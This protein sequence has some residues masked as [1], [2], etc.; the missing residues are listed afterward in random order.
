MGPGQAPGDESA[1]MTASLVELSVALRIVGHGDLA[2]H[3][4]L[5][6][7][8]REGRR[9]Y[10]DAEAFGHVALSAALSG[11]VPCRNRCTV[12]SGLEF[13]L[14]TARMMMCWHCSGVRVSISKSSTAGACPASR[15][16]APR[17]DAYC[18]YIYMPCLSW[19]PAPFNFQSMKQNLQLLVRLS[20]QL[21][22]RF[23]GYASS[24][25]IPMSEIL[26]HL[27]LNELRTGRA[28]AALQQPT[29]VDG[30]YGRQAAEI[31]SDSGK[32]YWCQIILDRSQPMLMLFDPELETR[33]VG[34]SEVQDQSELLEHILAVI[35]STYSWDTPAY[36]QMCTNL[37]LDPD[38]G[39]PTFR[40]KNRRMVFN[41]EKLISSSN[42]A[43]RVDSLTLDLLDLLRTDIPA[44][45]RTY[46]NCAKMLTTQAKHID[47]SLFQA[48][49]D[50]IDPNR[51]AE[52]EG[53]H[54]KIY[55]LPSRATAPYCLFIGPW[56]WQTLDKNPQ[57][58]DLYD[59]FRGIAYVS[60][61][62]DKS[63]RLIVERLTERG[64]K[65]F[66][67]AEARAYMDRDGTYWANHHGH[68]HVNCAPGLE[69][70][71]PTKN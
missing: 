3:H 11:T 52:A 32:K 4:R 27:I 13:L 18:I 22:D 50:R 16:G 39:R 65:F 34:P 28:V 26:R 61:S 35:Q 71:P 56:V 19:C 49:F 6:S 66:D 38:D 33:S 1:S 51:I 58:L 2:E 62:E 30:H 60:P 7:T 42:T 63:S 45:H 69:P 59:D 55:F 48:A 44:E 9:I 15:N 41:L 57:T 47:N 8:V 29:L 40:S 12:R 14:L 24:Y 20:D 54:S 53:F 23:K 67:F 21:R 70:R 43:P 36:R 17:R 5:S 68:G 46:T 10:P 31:R 37:G 25:G 64:V